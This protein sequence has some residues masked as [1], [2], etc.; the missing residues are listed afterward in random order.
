MAYPDRTN[1]DIE[2]LNMNSPYV[3]PIN[4]KGFQIEVNFSY[5]IRNKHIVFTLNP[6]DPNAENYQVEFYTPN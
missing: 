5:T 1:Y 6:D 4:T 2:T 3:I